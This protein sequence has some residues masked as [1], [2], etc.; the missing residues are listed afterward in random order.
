MCRIFRNKGKVVARVVGGLGNQLFIYAAAKRLALANNA[1][2]KLDILSGYD[3]DKYGRRFGLKHFNINEEIASP[4]ESYISKRG[5]WRRKQARKINR[6]IPF[7]YQFY[8]KQE[9]PYESRLIDLRFTRSLYLQGYWQDERY[10]KDVEKVIRDSFVIKTP[11][12]SQN[13][14]WAQKISESN[15][16]CVHARR[17][18]YKFALSSEYYHRAVEYIAQKISN[19]HFFCFSDDPEWI[20]NNFS[21][22]LPFTVLDHNREDKDYEDLW[23]MNKCRHYV[24]ANS[25]F[26]WWGAWLNPDPDKIVIAPANWGYDTAVPEAWKTI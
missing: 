21:T 18:N 1:V 10:F 7:P 22:D 2:L 26:S 23:L 13:I 11:H 3:R 20:L 8:I 12:D 14:K 19:P 17:I 15:A 24:I 5:A 16:V 9:R 25:S 6:H 4:W